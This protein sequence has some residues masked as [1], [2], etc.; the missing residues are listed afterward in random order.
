[1]RIMLKSLK[2]ITL[3]LCVC[4]FVSGCAHFPFFMHRDTAPKIAFVIDDVGYHKAYKNYVRKIGVPMTYAV[5]PF[6]DC[7]KFMAKFMH[8]NGD[9]IILHMPMASSRNSQNKEK[10]MLYPGMSRDEIRNNIAAC[11]KQ[12]PF[13]KGVNNH[14][15]SAFT[16]DYQGMYEALKYIKSQDLYFLD[17]LT[18]RESAASAVA[19]DLNMDIAVRDVF[20]DNEKNKPYIKKQIN[21]L[22]RVALKHGKAIGIGHYHKV[23]LASIAESIPDLRKKGIEFVVVSE[24]I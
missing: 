5:I 6:T 3:F 17:S 20:L 14:K 21:Q 10:Y 13:A 18:V 16:K 7:D 11:I 12:V 15:G 22:A 9:Q 24:I 4:F 23:T 1:M 19:A 8:E 2:K